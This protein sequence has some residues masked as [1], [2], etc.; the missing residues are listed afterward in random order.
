MWLSQF[1]MWLNQFLM[2]LSH[3]VLWLTTLVCGYLR[4]LEANSIRFVAKPLSYVAKPL[5][6]VA[7]PFS[8]VVKPLGF[9]AQERV[10]LGRED[11]KN[12]VKFFILRRLQKMPRFPDAEPDIAALADAMI[13]GYTAHPT[14]FPSADIPGLGTQASAYATVKSAQIDAMAA[15]QVATETKNVTLASLE[16]RMRNELKKSEVDVAS[17]P[18]KL[19][20]IGWGPKAPPG[21]SVAPGQP[22]NLDP[23][24]QGAGTL[25]L[26]WKGPARGTGGTVRTYV[27]ERR[28]QPAGGGEFGD[29]AQVAIAIETEATLINQ[30][31]GPQLEYRVKA[32]NAGGESTPSNTAAVVL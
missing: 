19:E 14:D 17:E 15:A 9:L 5:R 23:V 7:K 31:R 3:L 6:F 30:P 22:R 25:F 12:G 18:E 24:V 4:S 13:A 28:D 20:Y 8:Y 16:E 11:I 10:F 2:W 21:P 26:D 1:V 32:V 27:I 29:W